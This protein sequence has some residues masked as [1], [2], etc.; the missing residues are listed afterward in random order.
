MS[1]LLTRLTATFVAPPPDAPARAPRA[2]AP[3]E[4]TPPRVA[5]ARAGLTNVVAD[6][7]PATALLPD[8]ARDA[9]AGDRRSSPGALLTAV[10]V[11]ARPADAWAAG[12]AVALGLLAR[13]QAATAVVAAWSGGEGPSAAAPA[14][15]AARR[16]A[17]RLTDR[18]HD[19][20]STG[21][22]VLVVL[23]GDAGP[24]GA[25]AARVAAALGAE[26]AVTV[27]AGP[28]DEGVDTLLAGQDRAVVAAAGAEDAVA[29]LAASS[30]ALTGATVRVLDT[31][32]PGPA[33]ALA[34]TGVALL[35]PL[36]AAV[37][38]ALR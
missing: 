8:D 17:V 7:P 31:S 19:A 26:P 34:A 15:P 10:G 9:N 18:G 38:G 21:R 14:T 23:A 11:L 16:L 27:L 12:G 2:A 13:G 35:A 37:E 29:D 4:S 30:L 32:A 5:P 36:R 22:L 1:G 25:E 3:P 24:A 28:R 20:R 6:P 33:R